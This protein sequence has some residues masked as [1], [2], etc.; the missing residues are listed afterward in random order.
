MMNKV[1]EAAK[2][3]RDS[4]NTRRNEAT[5][6]DEQY[7][8]R[9]AAEDEW[10]GGI[11]YKGNSISWSHSKAENYKTALLDAWGELTKIGVPCDGNTSVAQA[12]ARF[13]ADCGNGSYTRSC[14]SMMTDNNMT[15][16]KLI[17]SAPK[18]GT[19]VWLYEGGHQFV[20][21][22]GTQDGPGECGVAMG[23]G[24]RWTDVSGYGANPTHWMPK[25]PNP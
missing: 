10:I 21:Y 15:M 16:W 14:L 1:I 7:F 4:Q 19:S 9:L 6:T 17:E 13:C 5:E 18:D 23:Y 22:W 11:S 3:I 2:A 8:D 24:L 20:G 25:P 12:I